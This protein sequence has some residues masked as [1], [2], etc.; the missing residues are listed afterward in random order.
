M[1]DLIERGDALD[2]LDNCDFDSYE[3]YSRTFDAINDIP[4]VNRW[5]PCSERMPEKGFVLAHDTGTG[6]FYIARWSDE[7]DCW[8]D[9]FLFVLNYSFT[10]WMPLPEPHEEV[11]NEH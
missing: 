5:I 11:Q 10:H 3:D 7:Y 8:Y 9:V 2:C 4:S 6:A 1:A